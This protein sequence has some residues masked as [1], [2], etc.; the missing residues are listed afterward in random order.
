[1]E[2]FKPG[3]IIKLQDGLIVIV[4]SY[5]TVKSSK[6]EYEVVDW[7]SFDMENIRGCTKVKSHTEKEK[8]FIDEEVFIDDE[9]NVC[10]SCETLCDT[11]TSKLIDVEYP[12]MDKAKFIASNVKSY[13]IDKL[14]TNFDF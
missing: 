4:Y 8:V 6:T 14:T 1:M 12:G 5:R 2:K 7:I 3:N 10:E 13:I 9:D 11:C